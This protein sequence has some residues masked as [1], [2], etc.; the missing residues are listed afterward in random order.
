[1]VSSSSDKLRDQITKI[2]SKHQ[3]EPEP[4]P[5]P[6]PELNEEIWEQLSA[7]LEP[8]TRYGLDGKPLK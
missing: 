7:P 1:M 5:S 8:P 4:E 6:Y 2:F 3:F